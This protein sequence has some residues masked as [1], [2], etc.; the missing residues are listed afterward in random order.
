[1][2]RNFFRDGL[3]WVGLAS[4]IVGGALYFSA[5]AAAD[6]VTDNAFQNALDSEGITYPSADYAITTGH[7]VCTL[8]D[9]GNSWVAVSYA[10]ARN[11]TLDVE[12]AAFLVGASIGAYCDE[13]SYLFYEE[14]LA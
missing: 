2:I 14:E 4:A 1:M 13:C 5:P 8:L 12:D 7:Q 10:I 3:H 9:R 11:S 6:P